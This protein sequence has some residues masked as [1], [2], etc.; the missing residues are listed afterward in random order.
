MISL[1][2]LAPGF[3]ALTIVVSLLFILVDRKKRGV[4]ELPFISFLIPTHNDAGYIEDTIK[5]I[6]KSYDSKKFEIV[7]VNDKSTDNTS[8]VLARLNKK[9][10][11]KLINNKVNK[12]KAVTINDSVSETNGDIIFMIDSDIILNKKSVMDIIKRFKSDE[13]VGGVSCNYAVKNRD[14]FFPMML[15]I[16]YSM[17]SFIQLS[18]N[19]FSTVSMWGGCMAFRRKAFLE[20]GK[21]SRNNLT[22]DM[23]A[24]LKL[25]EHGWK[26]EQSACPVYACVPED[27]KAWYR[28][29]MRWSGGG[30]QNFIKH[31]KIF[32]K[33][34]LVVLFLLSTAIFAVAFVYNVISGLMWLKSGYSPASIT[35][36]LLIMLAFPLF[37][38]PYVLFY[39]GYRKNP[40]RLLLVFPYAFIYYPIFMIACLIGFLK[41]IWNYRTLEKSKRAW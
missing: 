2:E 22:E 17:L 7:I 9:Y 16:E 11:F 18:Y 32:M 37:T 10:K 31:Y 15:D 35:E 40:G 39:K 3:M 36:N 8:E 26:A 5:N 30:M 24:A 27:F 19:F 34:P 28:Q 12:G 4:K 38:L 23:D 41:V 6:Y 25:K 1:N 20:I 21:L 13:N 29:K 14:G 33:N